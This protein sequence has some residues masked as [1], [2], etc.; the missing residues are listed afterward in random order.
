MARGNTNG[1]PTATNDFQVLD[2]RNLD[3]NEGPTNVDRRHTADAE[4]PLGAAV[5]A[6]PD[7]RRRRADR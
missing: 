6:R 4:R 2:E 5:A 3:Q 1:T 7:R